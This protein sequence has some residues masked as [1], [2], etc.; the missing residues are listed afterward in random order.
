MEKSHGRGGERESALKLFGSRV[1]T[2]LMGTIMRWF[3]GGE[4]LHLPKNGTCERRSLYCLHFIADW[5]LWRVARPL[6]LGTTDRTF[7]PESHFSDFFSFVFVD[8]SPHLLEA[9]PIMSCGASQIT[10]H[11]NAKKR[12]VVLLLLLR[13]SPRVEVNTLLARLGKLGA[14]PPLQVWQQLSH[15]KGP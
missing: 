12:N 9:R 8:F 14:S 2:D 13:S 6:S 7:C 4:F 3:S 15:D 10:E 11:A 5:P 1:V